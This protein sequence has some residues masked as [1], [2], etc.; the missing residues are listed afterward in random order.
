[1]TTFL[2]PLF[3][4]FSFLFWLLADLPMMLLGLIMVPLGLLFC[5]PTTRNMPKLFWPWDNDAYGIDGDGTWDPATQTGSGWKGPEHTAGNYA[6]FWNRFVWL[7]IRNATNNFDYALGFPQKEGQEWKFIGDPTTTDGGVSGYVYVECRDTP[8][9]WFPS[10][11]SFYLVHQYA[12]LPSKCLRM[13]FGWKIHDNVI[14]QYAL[15][16]LGKPGQLVA[17]INP[18]MGFTPLA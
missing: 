16:N 15:A 1:M 7:A 17:L 4:F 13:Y 14:P 8:G 6:S 3:I 12:W 11:F 18:L 9:S 5:G 10:A 2:A